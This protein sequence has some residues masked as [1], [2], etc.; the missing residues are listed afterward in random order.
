MRNDRHSWTTR[1]AKRSSLWGFSAH[2]T[3]NHRHCWTPGLT[4]CEAVVVFDDQSMHKLDKLELHAVRRVR[5]LCVFNRAELT[6]GSE[7]RESNEQKP[8]AKLQCKYCRKLR[9][10]KSIQSSRF[11][12]SVVTKCETIRRHGLTKYEAVVAFGRLRSRNAKRPSG[13]LKCKTVIVVGFCVARDMR[14]AKLA[15]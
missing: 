5:A 8:R 6:S 11:W 9:A 12:S 15:H 1:H 4:K 14:N 2:E 7:T 10:K 3:R 13:L